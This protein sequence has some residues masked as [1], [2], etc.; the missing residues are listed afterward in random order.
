MITKRQAIA[1]R[2]QM[3]AGARD[4]TDEEALSVPMLFERWEADKEYT[5]GTRLYHDGV[6]YRVL[7]DHTS[8]ADWEPKNAVSLYAEVLIPD[9]DVIPEWVQPDSTNPY[10]KGDKVRHNDKIWVSTVD[11]NVWEPGT[12][13][14][15]LEVE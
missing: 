8:Q 12:P 6:L 11:N 9:P 10:M 15:W 2:R 14:L 13:G 5:A 4:I 3:V 7:T 1:Y